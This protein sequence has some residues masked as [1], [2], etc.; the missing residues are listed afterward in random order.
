MKA[1]RIL[2]FSALLLTLLSGCGDASF[3]TDRN[4]LIAIASRGEND[5]GGLNVMTNRL[6]DLCIE[7]GFRTHYEMCGNVGQIQ[8]AQLKNMVAN[9]PAA[10]AVLFASDAAA[11][12]AG[13]KA[14]QAAGIPVILID[15]IRAEEDP[16]G[17]A[18]RVF[19]EILRHVE[20]V[21]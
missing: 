12:D 1:I 19:Q 14:V 15:P 8:N 2:I 6:Q 21:R 16:K 3:T 13:R 20:P 5:G 4:P 9:H 17:E 7:A 18:D 11:I 10:L